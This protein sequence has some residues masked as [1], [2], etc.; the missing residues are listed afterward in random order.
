MSFGPVILKA[1]RALDDPEKCKQFFQGHVDVLRSYGVEPVNSAKNSWFRDPKVYG[2]IA[3]FEGKVVG[4]V[5]IHK[6]GGILPLPVEDSIGYI[7]PNI[8]ELI[9]KN[10]PMGVGEACGLWNARE[11]AGQGLSYVLMR[12]MI[13]LTTKIDVYRLISLSSDHTVQMCRELGY[14]VIHSLGDNGDFIYP[15]PEYIA[16]VTLLNTKTLLTASPYNREVVFSLREKPVQIR[17]EKGK[18]G[19]V[20]IDYRLEL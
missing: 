17:D 1:F 18:K 6:V 9:K 3:E 7:D 13:A 15:T 14:E 19:I 4:G 2:I 20:C 5:K 16:R 8:Y 11:V 12:S 10:E